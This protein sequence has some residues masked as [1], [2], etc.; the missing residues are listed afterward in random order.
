MELIAVYAA[1]VLVLAMWL[2]KFT[3][4]AILS[5][6]VAALA[7]PAII[8][9]W[10]YGGTWAHF[11]GLFAVI[12]I[13]YGVS[14]MVQHATRRSFGPGKSF[15]SVHQTMRSTMLSIRASLRSS[16]S[17]S[18]V[19]AAGLI[20]AAVTITIGFVVETHGELALTIASITAV[21]SLSVGTYSAS[22]RIGD[23]I[24][25][26]ERTATVAVVSATV[27]GLLAFLVR[28]VWFDPEIQLAVTLLFGC[29]IAI[30]SAIGCVCLTLSVIR[31]V[32]H[33]LR[34]FFV[35]LTIPLLGVLTFGYPA[36]IIE[37]IVFE[38]HDI[39][40]TSFILAL[41]LWATWFVF[42]PGAKGASSLSPR[43]RHTPP[44]SDQP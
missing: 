39:L 43:L 40:E 31:G 4:S 27:V 34:P 14:R 24:L 5:S 19:I 30:I 7:T 33:E 9:Y 15:T 17:S 25:A 18:L 36:E 3:R 22:R 42:G 29:Q 13:G 16:R 23:A 44:G 26:M 32:W 35:G 20:A 6:S 37:P 11:E 41:M 38:V 12:L 21:A 28:Q 8:V 1:A 2:A 10:V